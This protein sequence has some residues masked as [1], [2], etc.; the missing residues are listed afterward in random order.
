MTQKEIDVL[1]ELT[2]TVH[3][4]NWFGKR[5]DKRDRD[6]VQ[7][8]VAKQLAN[9]LGIYTIP[10]GASWGV[11]TT[12]ENFDVYWSKNSEIIMNEIV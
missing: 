3:E 4:K 9:S 11:L 8:W 12:E 5:K 2:L 7:E 1:F 6:E 10:C